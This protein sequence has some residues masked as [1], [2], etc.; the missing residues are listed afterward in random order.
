[1]D[2]AFIALR[3][4]GIYIGGQSELGAVLERIARTV[5]F[6]AGKV[7]VEVSPERIEAAEKRR[8]R[9]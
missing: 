7:L 9:I 8:R 1:V 2:E 5:L 6:V 4:S 3:D